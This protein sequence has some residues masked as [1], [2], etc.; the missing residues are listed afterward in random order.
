MASAAAEEAREGPLPDLIWQ[1]PVS[2]CEERRLDVAKNPDDV[3]CSPLILLFI[4]V[5]DLILFEY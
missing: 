1:A 2:T 4:V 3:D 5:Y